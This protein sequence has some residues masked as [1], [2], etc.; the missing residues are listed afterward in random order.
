M[1]SKSQA[2]QLKQE[3]WTIFGQ[4]MQPVLSAEGEKINWVN[5]KTGEK[6]IY[7]KMHADSRSASIAI[8]I[9]HKDSLV[10]QL[11][12]E[13]FISLEK[14]FIAN[15]GEAWTWSLHEQDEHGNVVSRISSNLE[16]VNIFNKQDWPQL[17]SFFKT[18]MISLDKFWSEVKYGFENLH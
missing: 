3:F 13:H 7:F 17:I 9:R 18:G 12:F 10:Q 2:S 16:P 1:Y 8:E 6:D 4:Y 14:I 15:A 11:F 5:Y